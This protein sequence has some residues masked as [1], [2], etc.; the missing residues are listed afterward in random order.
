MDNPFDASK[1]ILPKV[2]YPK[3]DIPTFSYDI[4]STINDDM[5]EAIAA[6]EEHNR[7]ELERKEEVRANTKQMA[8]DTREMKENL[9]QV[10]H[11]QNNHIQLL[12]QLLKNSQEQTSQLKKLFYSQEDSASVQKEIL[13]IM[14]N[15]G[16]DFKTLTIEKGLDAVFQAIAI[17]LSLN[18]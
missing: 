5:D 2:E 10:I 17:Y 7:A 4:A 3:I 11:N 1:M 14:A 13:E 12:E 6:I 9:Y 8:E 15:K 16:V 18:G